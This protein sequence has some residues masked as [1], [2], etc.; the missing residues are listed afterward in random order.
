MDIRNINIHIKPIY[1]ITFKNL[2]GV[3]GNELILIHFLNQILGRNKNN[4]IVDLEYLNVEKVDNIG[5]ITNKKKRGRLST[6]VPK[7][8]TKTSKMDIHDNDNNEMNNINIK[9]VL[10]Y[11]NFQN[12]LDLKLDD[13][14]NCFNENVNNLLEKILEIED[15]TLRE[16]IKEQIN[17]ILKEY[18]TN[19]NEYFNIENNET[20]KEINRF[21]N[22]MANLFKPE[23]N[24]SVINMEATTK[25]DE[26]INIE[27]Q[28][29]E[30]RE[31]YKRT[32]F[33][34]SKIIHPS[35]LFGNKYK[36]IPKVIMINILN[37]NL[38]NNTKE[39]MTIPHWEFTLK[40]KNTNEEKGFKDLLNIHFIELPKYKEYAVKHR[41]KMIDNYSW[42]LF[43][44]DPNDEYFKRDDIPEVFINAR[45]QLFL[46]QADPDFIELYEQREKEIMDEKSKMEGKYDE[47][48]IKGLIKGKKEG[49]I[50]GRKEGEK[51]TELKYLMKSLKKGE[52]L[53]E[54][55]DDYK[56]IFTEEELEIINSF[57][58]DKSY[59]IKDLALQLDLD[60]DIILEV[61]EKVNLDVQ[62]RKEKK[63]KIKIKY[64]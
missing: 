48:L 57:V 25:D 52:K 58:E 54:I 20:T 10:F 28:I 12:F 22:Y 45:E 17:N 63:R 31:M 50:Q 30:D 40:D 33:Y 47:G 5:L 49:V 16:D 53:K 13:L 38:L 21:K 7:Y 42:I 11:N 26:R 43:L 9:S 14:L 29:N 3:E 4:E 19:N 34:A 32:L 2:F 55:K 15:I 8:F 62:E 6:K 59:K 23:E 24:D 60:E 39:E 61:C 18:K 27:I 44:N 46:L 64:F 35:L 1:D 41:N 51:K 56:E 37:F 36:K